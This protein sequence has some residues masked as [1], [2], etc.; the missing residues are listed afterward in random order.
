LHVS[1][2]AHGFPDT[3]T[4]VPLAFV[5]PVHTPDVLHVSP[6][7]QTFPFE[8]AVPDARSVWCPVPPQTPVVLHVSL[9]MHGFPV[10]QAPL[11]L[12][13]VPPVHVPL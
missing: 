12:V 9:V 5:P 2:V 3:Q 6:V 10:E 13:A 8:Q 11:A 4:V 1:V 7:L